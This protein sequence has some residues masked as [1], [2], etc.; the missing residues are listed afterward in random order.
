MTATQDQQLGYALDST[1][2]GIGEFTSTMRDRL[3]KLT[4]EDV[5]A[6]IRKHLSA[7]DLSVV[8]IAKDAKGLKEK[9]VA[10]AFSPI[11]YEAEK[12]K[13]LLDEDQVIGA[14]KL[15]LAPEAVR[16]TP[17]EEVFAR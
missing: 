9:L 15:G 1:W 8:I 14:R 3:Q 11:R 5:N 4:R 16:I 7:G 6:A 12:P 2:Y 17:V 13:E 10:D